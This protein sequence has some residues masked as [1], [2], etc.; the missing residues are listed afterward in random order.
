MGPTFGLRG[1]VAAAMNMC[2]CGNQSSSNG[3][4]CPRCEALRVMGLAVDATAEEIRST[5]Q[6][7]VK[8]WHPD[9]FQGDAGLKNAGEAKLKEINA[10][11][12]LLCS[13]RWKDA[14]P[15]RERPA[16][17]AGPPKEP[18]AEAPVA[19][20]AKKKAAA[21]RKFGWSWVGWAIPAGWI[22]PNVG[23]S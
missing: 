15:R 19:E 1:E 4:L 9:R 23:V 14:P 11:Y 7:L 18:A 10:A 3:A 6:V 21:R 8:V 13:A 22:S 20:P 17:D 5:Y 12:T 2:A 16:A